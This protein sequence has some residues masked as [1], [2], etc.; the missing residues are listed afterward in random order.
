M[1]KAEILRKGDIKVKL[2]IEC[3]LDE[4]K[5][6]GAVCEGSNHGF[7]GIVY[8]VFHHARSVSK[9]IEKTF[10]SEKNDDE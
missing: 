2:E 9:Q 1:I 4:L 6:L 8:D 3:T 7:R 5:T 10:N